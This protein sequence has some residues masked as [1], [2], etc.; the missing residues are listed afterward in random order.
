MSNFKSLAVPPRLAQ[1]QLEPLL[2]AVKAGEVSPSGKNISEFY[3]QVEFD[4]REKV[5]LIQ[6]ELKIVFFNMC[7]GRNLDLWASDEN[8]SDAHIWLLSELDW[9]MARSEYKATAIELAKK[10]KAHCFFVPEY[11]E[12][13]HGTRSEQ[14]KFAD[15]EFVSGWHGNAILSRVPIWDHRALRLP[16]SYDWSKDNE[17][18]LGGQ[19]AQAVSLDFRGTTLDIVNLHL[20]A[21]GDSQ[22]RFL[23]FE[24]AKKLYNR[25]ETVLGGDLNTSSTIKS[26]I[27]RDRKKFLKLEPVLKSLYEQRFSLLPEDNKGSFILGSQ[28][29]PLRL[30]WACV[31]GLKVK[32]CEWLMPPK[33]QKRYLSDHL[34]IK[35]SISLS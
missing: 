20:A 33:Y 7:R 24:E 28:R 5:G 19:V 15:Q 13:T 6:D 11:L 26:L 16:T 9:G 35:L 10:L 3:F 23:Q 27:S 30:D 18:R 34:G 32:S 14:K 4:G 17:K 31:R 22:E 25:I 12:L 21:R 2:E 29:I 1:Y 8:F